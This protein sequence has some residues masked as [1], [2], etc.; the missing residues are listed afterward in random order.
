MKTKNNFIL[1][2]ISLL[3]L[4]QFGCTN[5]PVLQEPDVQLFNQTV[6]SE[7][8]RDSL[9]LGKLTAGMPRFVVSQLFMNYSDGSMETKIPVAT[10]GSKQ[11]LQEEEGWNRKYVDPDINVFLDKYETSEGRLYVWY[12]RPDFYTMDVSQRDTLCVF[13]EDTVYCSVINYLNKSS[14]LSVRDSLPQILVNTK[15]Y[16]EIRYNDHPWREVSY[17]YNL[18]IL[19]NAKT[20]KLGD[21]NYEFY[22]IE[23]LEFNNEPVTSFNWREVNNED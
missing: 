21:T 14:V 9:I 17:W 20:F 22:P 23:L 13:Y 18:E 4:S 16:A 1:F 7:S 3:I 2:F 15:L 19:S 10:L 5:Y 6:H 11:R 12:Q 8:L